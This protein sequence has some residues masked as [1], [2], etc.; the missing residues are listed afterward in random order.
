M[1]NNIFQPPRSGAKRFWN[2]HG[3]NGED[4]EKCEGKNVCSRR[5]GKALM[6]AAAVAKTNHQHAQTKA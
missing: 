6:L 1:T 4:K 2:L 3:S 5:I